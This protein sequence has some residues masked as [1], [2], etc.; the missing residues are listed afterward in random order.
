LFYITGGV[1]SW[2][3]ILIKG[4]IT[5]GKREANILQTSTVHSE[6]HDNIR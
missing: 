6:K 2:I 4:D 5:T 1:A 3:D